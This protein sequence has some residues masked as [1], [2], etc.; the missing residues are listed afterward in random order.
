MVGDGRRSVSSRL[1]PISIIKMECRCSKARTQVR[2]DP[3]NL[4]SATS[5]ACQERALQGRAN[6]ARCM[7]QEGRGRIHR[8]DR[9]LRVG[10]AALAGRGNQLDTGSGQPETPLAD[11]MPAMTLGGPSERAPRRTP[12]ERRANG[13]RRA[14]DDGKRGLCERGPIDVEAMRKP[15]S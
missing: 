3:R 13:G 14:S 15:L 9:A 2:S 6:R 7:V 4:L 1:K 5:S 12:R 11:R 10:L 8:P